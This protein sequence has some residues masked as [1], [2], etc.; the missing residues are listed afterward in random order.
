MQEPEV[1][2]KSREVI[3]DHGIIGCVQWDSE[4]GKGS[5][6]KYFCGQSGIIKLLTLLKITSSQKRNQ[7]RKL[8]RILDPAGGN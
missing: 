5:S 3:E 4:D 6:G 1:A 8:W 2:I 7:E